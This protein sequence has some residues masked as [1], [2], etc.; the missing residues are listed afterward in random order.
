MYRFQPLDLPP[1]PYRCPNQKRIPPCQRNA[2]LLSLLCFSTLGIR[3]SRFL[4]ILGFENSDKN[5]HTNSFLGKLPF[6]CPRHIHPPPRFQRIVS[7]TLLAI[8]RQ[9][10][11]PACLAK[12]REPAA[13]FQTYPSL[14]NCPRCL[15]GMGP[16]RNP[17][18][19]ARRRR[20]RAG[21]WRRQFPRRSSGPSFVPSA[22]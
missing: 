6:P 5:S 2:S 1:V 17:S 19:P 10:R 12:P 20:D 22:R 8:P 9:S 4:W 15:A 21:L 18:R 3:A 11:G 13:S 7:A 16:T 14:R